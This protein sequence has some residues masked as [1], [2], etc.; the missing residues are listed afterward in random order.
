VAF[1]GPLMGPSPTWDVIP[2]PMY[3]SYNTN[4]L[5]MCDGCVVGLGLDTM[6]AFIPGVLC[7]PAQINRAFRPFEG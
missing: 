3:L 7:L 4:I 1:D 2:E 5:A 6:E